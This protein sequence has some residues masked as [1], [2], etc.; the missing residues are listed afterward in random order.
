MRRLVP[1]ASLLVAAACC[2]DPAPRGDCAGVVARIEGVGWEAAPGVAWAVDGTDAATLTCDVLP[3]ASG[4]REPCDIVDALD[5]VDP[6]GEI[7]KQAPGYVAFLHLGLKDWPE[8]P[9]QA[10]ITL[11]WPGGMVDMHDIELTDEN[12]VESGN[13]CPQR[14]R[15]GE[16][17]LDAEEGGG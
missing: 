11:D 7:I 10:T 4:D 16:L 2:P 12:V 9:E 17:K 13:E 5:D 6:H 14:C 1:I 15:T 8:V 3:E